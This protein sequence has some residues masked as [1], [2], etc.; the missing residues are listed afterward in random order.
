MIS[1][2]QDRRLAW[3]TGQDRTQ[4]AHHKILAGSRFLFPTYANRRNRFPEPPDS[5]QKLQTQ[6]GSTKKREHPHHQLSCAR[7]NAIRQ[8]IQW[9]RRGASSYGFHKNLIR[10]ALTTSH[11][12]STGCDLLGPSIMTKSHDHRQKGRP[13]Q[14]GARER[15]AFPV[16]SGNRTQPRKSP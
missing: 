8:E 3:R 14:A 1:V 10:F 6:P 12:S 15:F 16:H 7:S 11:H 4:P 9:S 2:H 5:P 13:S